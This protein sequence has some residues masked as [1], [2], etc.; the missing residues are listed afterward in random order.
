MN[1]VYYYCLSEDV[2][3]E[4]N[5]HEDCHLLN[6]KWPAEY[7]GYILQDCAE[8]Y[9]ICHDGFSSDW[10]LNF[11]VFNETGALIVSGTVSVE[12]NPQFSCDRIVNHQAPEVKG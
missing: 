8:D 11:S 4:L 7:A 12:M 9:W 1:N 3:L 5:V 2:D 6:S 10:P